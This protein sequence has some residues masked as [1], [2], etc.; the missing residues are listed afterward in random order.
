[1]TPKE[2]LALMDALDSDVIDMKV[3]EFHYLSRAALMK[4][5]RNLEKFRPHPGP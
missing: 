2:Y 3:D 5:E 4:N 1:M